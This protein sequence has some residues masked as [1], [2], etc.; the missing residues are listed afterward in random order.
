LLFL[1]DS[2]TLKYYFVFYCLTME[3]ITIKV[4][5]AFARAMEKAMKPLYS[6]KTEFIRAALREKLEREV[7]KTH[8]LKVLEENFPK[9][10][11]PA[12]DAEDERIREEVAQRLAKKY[13]V[14]LPARHGHKISSGSREGT[15]L[16]SS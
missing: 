14:A 9:K 4:D 5:P 11:A 15:T 1:Y 16:R 13:G 8:A 12:N 7:Q 2:A 3:S 6:T 10:K